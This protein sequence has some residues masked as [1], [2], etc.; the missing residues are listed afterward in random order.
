LLQI[1]ILVLLSPIIALFTL[2]TYTAY[3]DIFLSRT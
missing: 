3:R 1:A 2:A